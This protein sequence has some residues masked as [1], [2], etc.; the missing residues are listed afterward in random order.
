[1][2][3]DDRDHG[4]RTLARN[5]K[6]IHTCPKPPSPQAPKPPSLRAHGRLAAQSS[7]GSGFRCNL[8]SDCSRPQPV[9]SNTLRLRK[10]EL[11]HTH[12]AAPIDIG[13]G[14]ELARTRRFPPAATT[15]FQVTRSLL[16]DCI[17][18][19]PPFPLRCRNDRAD[20]C[21]D[22]RQRR[23]ACLYHYDTT[24]SPK[25]RGTFRIHQAIPTEILRTLPQSLASILVS[26]L[27][28][29]LGTP[30]DC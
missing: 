1:M 11:R 28:V 5:A 12:S 21:S 14:V 16:V 30:L 27:G 26:I 18:R 3:G 6:M 25:L 19:P 2:C 17:A 9:P 4:P 29:A 8:P 7:L 10:S 15:F 22:D 13:L 24:F 20:G 23:Y